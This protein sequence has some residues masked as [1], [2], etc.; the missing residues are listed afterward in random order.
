[1]KHF[2]PT[3][4][5]TNLA[6]HTIVV[7]LQTVVPHL[8]KFMAKSHRIIYKRKK[9]EKFQRKGRKLKGKTKILSLKKR[10]KIASPKFKLLKKERVIYISIKI[11]IIINPRHLRKECNQLSVVPL[12]ENAIK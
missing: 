5:M 4:M 9:I 3:I 7:P 11:G 10:K 1:M 12:R 8:T 6:I 2:I